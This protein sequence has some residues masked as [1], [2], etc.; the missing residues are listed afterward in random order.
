MSISVAVPMYILRLLRHVPMNTEGAATDRPSQ[1]PIQRPCQS[2]LLTRLAHRPDVASRLGFP[3]RLVPPIVSVRDTAVVRTLYG[4]LH[5]SS[6]V[7]TV[8]PGA[9]RGPTG[10]P[11]A[12]RSSPRPKSVI[13]SS[14]SGDG[15]NRG[16]G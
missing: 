10:D 8:F 5:A 2:G 12:N 1:R 6:S 15:A 9:E 7:T 3:W 11:T 16:T 14:G 4:L 13:R